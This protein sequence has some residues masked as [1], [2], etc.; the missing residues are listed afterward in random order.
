M[1]VCA[2]RGSGPRPAAR[3]LR[4]GR[5]SAG[6]AGA[7]ALVAA[8]GKAAVAAPAP[9]ER[10]LADSTLVQELLRKTEENKEARQKA[11]LEDYYD[12]NFREYFEFEAGSWSGLG[13]K[14]E[15]VAIAEKWLA[16]HPRRKPV[17]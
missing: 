3:A 15:K 13:E 11:R 14:P 2:A 4:L 10:N 6:L 16:E 1:A 17:E 12:R 5:R 7:A 8:R 9:P